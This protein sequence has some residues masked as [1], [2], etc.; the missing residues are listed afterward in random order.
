MRSA[1]VRGSKPCKAW[2]RET[3][4]KTRLPADEEP[5]LF[6]WYVREFAKGDPDVQVAISKLV[7]G[8]NAA[9]FLPRI[10]VPVLGLC[11][12]GGQITSDAQVEMLIDGLADFEIHHLPTGYHM[13]Q[14]LYPKECAQ[15]LDAFCT[16][17]D[18]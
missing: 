2:V 4:Q 11:P 13:V 9:G 5:E 6:G 16:R 1:A 3:T 10:R 8:A 12:S 14:L 15:Y 7:N 18:A 17:V